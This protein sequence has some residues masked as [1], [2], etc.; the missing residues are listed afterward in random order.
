MISRQLGQFGTG[1]NTLSDVSKKFRAIQSERFFQLKPSKNRLQP[2]HR[3]ICSNWFEGR[4]FSTV[5]FGL[6]TEK[7]DAMDTWW[8]DYPHLIGSRNPTLADL[9]QLRKD[10]FSVLVCLL[11]EEEQ[12]PQYDITSATALGFEWHNIPV[13]DFCP[14]TIEQLEQFV[15]FIDS[16][17]SGTK[18]VLHCE[19]GI[20]RTG[21]FAAAYWITKGLTAPDAIV[22]IREARPH[23]VET[24]EQEAILSDF[25][26]R[27][28]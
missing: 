18:T 8:I 28:G 4:D 2:F 17:P 26:D 16:L 25:A 7:S 13:K 27:R 9:E 24:R 5:S 19:G 22:R 20:G 1:A 11:K 3:L 10:R 6:M 21:T 15:E 14:P 23:A 12:A